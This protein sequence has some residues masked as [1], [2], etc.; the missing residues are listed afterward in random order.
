MLLLNWMTTPPHFI[1]SKS[2]LG[3]CVELT[4]KQL[5]KGDETQGLGSLMCETCVLQA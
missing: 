1:G 4:G 2:F 3:S 5:A